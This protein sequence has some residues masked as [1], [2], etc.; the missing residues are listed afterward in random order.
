MLDADR[1]EMND[2]LPSPMLDADR[3]DRLS[4]PDRPRLVC[5]LKLRS[6]PVSIGIPRHSRGELILDPCN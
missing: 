6:R 1:I 3:I 4:I 2:R 5:V